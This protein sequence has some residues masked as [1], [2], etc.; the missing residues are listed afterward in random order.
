MNIIII[1]LGNPGEEYEQTKHNIGYRIASYL[2][3]LNKFPDFSKEY[4]FLISVGKISK[5]KIVLILPL[6]FMNK[7]GEA[8][9]EIIK[10]YKP[11]KKLKNSNRNDILPIIV[12]HDDSD[13][14]VGKV[15]IGIG[16]SSGGHRGVESII[17][18]L[19]SPNFI[20]FRIGI[21]PQR[22]KHKKAESIVLKKFSADE[23]KIMAKVIKKTALS[24]MTAA[25]D[26]IDS[27]YNQLPNL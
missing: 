5:D 16:K 23:E 6:T 2:Q 1:G 17:K 22:G 3:K 27:A 18:T 15:K 12:I 21:Q 14:P 20:R 19:K 7:S 24:I 11:N 9:R 13:L 10:K 26:S 8:V 4:N 25:T